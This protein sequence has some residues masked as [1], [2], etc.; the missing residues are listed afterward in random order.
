M[1][2]PPDRSE[3]GLIHRLVQGLDPTPDAHVVDLARRTLAFLRGGDGKAAWML[4]D[5]LVRLT[6][7]TDAQSLM[8]RGAAL[9]ALGDATAA[10]RDFDAAALADPE[11]RMVNLSRLRSDDPA[12]RERAIR[13][14]L[15]QPDD[16]DAAMLGAQLLADG[17][18]CL[19]L[20]V[21]G[22]EGISGRLFWTGP[23]RVTLTLDDGTER[24]R[25]SLAARDDV[26]SPP[27]SHTA[28]IAIAWPAGAAALK[29]EV[30]ELRAL[31]EPP[32]LRREQGAPSNLPPSDAATAPG[33]M[34]LL[35][36]YDAVEAVAACFESLR[37]SPPAS[38]PFR[39]VAIDDAAPTPGVSTLLD[40]LAAEGRITLLRNPLNLGFAGS[41]NRTLALRQPREDVLLLNADTIVP[42]GAIDRLRAAALSDAT[43]GTVTPLSNNGED[44]SLPRRFR[45]NPLP[46]DE[47][48]AAL[49]ALAST[50]N[51]GGLVDMP[52]GI[53]FCMYIKARLLDRI[54]PLSLAFGRGYYED[55]EFCLRAA[56]H[57]FRNVCATDV[58]VGHHGSVSFKTEKRALVRR[59]LP[60]LAQS[61]P[62]YRERSDAFV[63]ADPLR[64]PIG[65][66]ERAWL[67]HATEFDL[68]VTPPLPAA[69]GDHVA[70]SLTDTD[71][72]LIVAT[73]TP[74]GEDF[75]LCL[76]APDGGVPQNAALRFSANT[77]ADPAQDA[78]LARALGE[79]RP[80]RVVVVDPARLPR[81]LEAAL[82]RLG[83]LETILLA[84]LPSTS[85]A[86]AGTPP[87][88]DIVAPTDRMARWI[89]TMLPGTTVHRLPPPA[90]VMPQRQAGERFLAILQPM[91]DEAPSALRDA[92]LRERDR[93]SSG[94]GLCL[95]GEP[96]DALVL[97]SRHPVFATGEI[98]GD[99][100]D[101]WLARSGASALLL[102]TTEYGLGDPRLDAW[103]ASGL[104]VAIRAPAG[105]DAAG[106]LLRLDP[107]ASPD[108]SASRLWDW[109]EAL[110]D[111]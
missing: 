71:R 104:P 42:P 28:P 96:S 79:L 109:V 77:G 16:I 27:F 100:L 38:L 58:Y 92:L 78:E 88:A 12:L 15:R 5:R 22:S 67:A 24:R 23:D 105:D 85:V 55:V 94:H 56:Q 93:R 59:N 45:A 84:R 34:I 106:L 39:I 11:H 75:S 72:R 61:H 4:A 108:E 25:L 95:I 82:R 47:T 107:E 13:A 9:A 87:P 46:S 98:A 76:R 111:A 29:V 51:R 10:R 7:G 26:A 41:V 62:D 30:E 74:E 18:A 20:L 14:L 65:R 32:L 57:G 102:D 69:L 73:A 99:E 37:R 17:F 44:T 48:I 63:R 60:L 68:L 6:T 21:S 80:R 89:E 81:P 40:E 64:E 91:T 8:L 53:G 19:A 83:W 31:V 1:S 52:N 2:A 49:D 43:I 110:P 97:M 66:L 3:T 54:G 36:V 35:P 101:D 86:P 50:V 90:R 70:A 33:L 103:L